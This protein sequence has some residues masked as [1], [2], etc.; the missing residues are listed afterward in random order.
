MSLSLADVI[1]TIKIL[2]KEKEKFEVKNIQPGACSNSFTLDV[3]YNLVKGEPGAVYPQFRVSDFMIDAILIYAQSLDTNKK[4]PKESIE[5]INNLFGDT[6]VMGTIIRADKAPP[7]NTEVRKHF[8]SEVE[9]CQITFRN[10]NGKKAREGN[11]TVSGTV[12]VR[13][14]AVA[15]KRRSK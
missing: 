4:K 3:D 11:T 6:G 10:K 14:V 15:A 5:W 1:A 13:P 2:E 7:I 12:A 9:K 8:E